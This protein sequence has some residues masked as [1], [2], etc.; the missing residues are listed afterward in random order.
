[1]TNQLFSHTIVSKLGENMDRI[2]DL[3]SLKSK[4]YMS[5]SINLKELLF[6][7][8]N[9]LKCESNNVSTNNLSLIYENKRLII[10]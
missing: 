5:L 8:W 4:N 3:Q 10:S 2:V 1:M 9:L 6:A 7:Y